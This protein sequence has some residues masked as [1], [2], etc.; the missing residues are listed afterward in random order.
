MLQDEDKG[1]KW[2]KKVQFRILTSRCIG[3]TP[4]IQGQ[5]ETSLECQSRLF[6]SLAHQLPRAQER[7]RMSARSQP[8]HSLHNNALGVSY[9][10]ISRV[11][12]SCL[13]SP[14]NRWEDS[15]GPESVV[16]RPRISTLMAPLKDASCAE[17]E[18]K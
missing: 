10:T 7:A 12:S 6:L 15:P 17:A 9:V 14:L 2:A 5:K 1:L 8:R 13:H 11:G 16:M 18:E 3:E 4:G